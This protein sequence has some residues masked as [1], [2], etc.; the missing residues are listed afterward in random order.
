[1]DGHDSRPAWMKVGGTSGKDTC[2]LGAAP[3]ILIPGRDATRAKDA[4]MIHEESAIQE[5][6]GE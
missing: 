4:A 6:R 2:Y 5:D 3:R 1:M